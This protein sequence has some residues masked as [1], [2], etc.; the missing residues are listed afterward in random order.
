MSKVTIGIISD[1]HSLLRTEA[2]KALRGTDLI[3]HAGDIGKQ[4][5]LSSLKEIAPLVVVRGNIDR[6][7]WAEKLPLTESVET[8]GIL[9][10]ALHNL[11]DLEIDPQSE[12]VRAIISGHSH[13]PSIKW[14]D[15]VLYLNPGSAGPHRFK[16]PVTLALLEI[17]EGHIEPHL[18]ELLHER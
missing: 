10:Y 17:Y 4:E 18:V 6:G 16:L 1:T 12:G 9:I 13:I 5:I 8:G 2:V 11:E 7:E 14:K 15:E 3:I